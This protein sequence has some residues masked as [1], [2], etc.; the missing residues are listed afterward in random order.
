M[1]EQ[2]FT[3]RANFYSKNPRCSGRVKNFGRNDNPP[4]HGRRCNRCRRSKY[5]TG[6]NLIANAGKQFR[7]ERPH[8]STCDRHASDKIAR[9][10]LWPRT[11][12][13]YGIS[14]LTLR[15]LSTLIFTLR[16]PIRGEV[17]SFW[18]AR[19]ICLEGVTLWTVDVSLTK[20]V[21]R[22]IEAREFQQA[23]TVASLG[24][25]QVHR[26]CYSKRR[27]TCCITKPSTFTSHGCV[28]IFSLCARLVRSRSETGASW[29][30]PPS[31][32]WTSKRAGRRLSD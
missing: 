4:S 28:D 18:G 24:V 10:L 1:Q 30:C 17:Q 27:H 16:Q 12:R 8:I 26:R 11:S 19:V 29:V 25:T 9:R 21:Y 3:C 6:G 20:A 22:H 15:R 32:R 2:V 14:N 13:K 23:Y 7:D 31:K 5:C